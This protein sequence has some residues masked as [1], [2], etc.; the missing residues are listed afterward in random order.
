[1]DTKNRTDR[2]EK[3]KRE[4]HFYYICRVP[5]RGL[6][7]GLCLLWKEIVDFQVRTVYSF[8]MEVEVKDDDKNKRWMLDCIHAD[9]DDQRRCEQWSLSQRV[10]GRRA[11]GWVVLGDLKDLLPDDKEG[12]CHRSAASFSDFRNFLDKCGLLDVG[13]VVH[14]FTWFQKRQGSF[15]VKERLDRVLVNAKSLKQD[16]KREEEFWRCQSRVQWL[17]AGDKKTSSFHALCVQSRRHNQIRGL[18]F[19]TVNKDD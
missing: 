1:M 16:L 14:P 7:G 19:M 6:A 10:A 9:F 11:D 15:N 18:V 12:G 8:I 4:L 3:L 13:F 17:Q 5:P 2:L